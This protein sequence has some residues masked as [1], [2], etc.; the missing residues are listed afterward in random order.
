MFATFASALVLLIPSV[1]GTDIRVD[2]FKEAYNF[3]PGIGG[4]CYLG[5]G[6]GF[7]IATMF[8]A[9]IGDQIYASVSGMLTALVLPYNPRNDP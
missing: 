4:L 8:G 9:K 7:F 6:I 5:L 1:V 3:S 2:F